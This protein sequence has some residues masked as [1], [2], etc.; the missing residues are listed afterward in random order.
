M[1]D[2]EAQ[3]QWAL[4]L[5]VLQ[6]RAR[7]RHA[8]REDDLDAPLRGGL[9]GELDLVGRLDVS[10][11]DADGRVLDQRHY[12]E[13]DKFARD[14]RYTAWVGGLPLGIYSIEARASDGRSATGELRVLDLAEDDTPLVLTLR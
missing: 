7:G 5:E 12:R 3:G 10:V 13:V 8:V 2:G 9:E 14:G 4:H 1:S 11:L 6:D